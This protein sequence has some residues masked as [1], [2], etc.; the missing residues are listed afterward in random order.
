MGM[1]ACYMA[2]EEHQLSNLID[3]EGQALV[4]ALEELQENN[5]A[6]DIGK[7]W[8]GLHFI[9]TGTSASTPIEDD[10][11]SDAIVGI[12]VMD[13]D[14]FIAAI[15]NNELDAI[16]AAL[17]KVNIEQLRAEFNPSK[18][19]QAEIYPNI[20]VKEDKNSL[21]I[22]LEQAL[23]QLTAFYKNAMNSDRHI[24]VSIY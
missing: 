20:W 24:V 21:F 15:G 10:P 16:V 5:D 11:L 6:L 12:H 7:M 22:E 19:N 8:D 14:N 1:N 18:L 3:L 4:D 2:I 13:E 17:A 23:Q 9:L